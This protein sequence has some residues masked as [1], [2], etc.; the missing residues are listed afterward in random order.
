M[1]SGNINV[2]SVPKE[3]YCSPAFEGLI[4]TVGNM[5]VFVVPRM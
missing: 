2:P 5:G 1:G 4:G 3:T